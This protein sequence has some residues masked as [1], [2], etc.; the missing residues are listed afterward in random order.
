MQNAEQGSDTLWSRIQQAGIKP[1]DELYRIYD[2]ARFNDLIID[3]FSDPALYNFVEETKARGPK[4]ANYSSE[5]LQEFASRIYE[6]RK[7]NSNNTAG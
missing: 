1:K 7:N 6:L 2:I 4:F 5:R 3:K